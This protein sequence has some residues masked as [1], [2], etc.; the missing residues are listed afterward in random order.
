MVTKNK[1]CNNINHKIIQNCPKPSNT[2]QNHQESTER[3]SAHH[4]RLECCL[5][6]VSYDIK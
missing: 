2:R 4:T 1:S 6:P 3:T 5:V